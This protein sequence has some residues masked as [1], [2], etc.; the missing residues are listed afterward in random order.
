[1]QSGIYLLAEMYAALPNQRV[2][3]VKLSGMCAM[4]HRAALGL[5]A[6]LALLLPHPLRQ[7]MY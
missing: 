7:E 3:Y 4:S 5:T 2:Q 6:A 1:M